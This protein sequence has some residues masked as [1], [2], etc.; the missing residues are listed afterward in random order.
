VLNALAA[1]AIG[2][3]LGASEKAIRKGLAGFAGVRRRFTYIGQSGGVRVVDDYGHHP[4][5]ISNVLKA[6]RAVSH[7]RVIAVVQP[8]RY[9]RLKDLFQ[10]FCR[11]FNDADVVIVADVYP[12]G[13]APIEGANRTALAEGLR[14]HGHRNVLELSGPTAL[15]ALIAAEARDGDLV[16]C[17]GA[18]DITT[19]AQA[20]PAQLEALA[21]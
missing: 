13:E 9:T 16:V 17:L 8:H 5:E 3:E 18:G 15:P 19:W 12:A 11:C 21:A 14:R 10:E 6:A 4:V 20:L 7:G 2:R 1:I